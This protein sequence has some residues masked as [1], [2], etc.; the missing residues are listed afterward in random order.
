M[1]SIPYSDYVIFVDESG[2][3]SLES[4]DPE[5][6]VFVLDFC[7]FRKEHYTTAVV[8]R[9]QEFKFRHFGHDLVVLHEHDI[10]RQKP[11]FVFLKSQGKREAFMEELTRL[12]DEAEFTIVAS[13]IDKESHVELYTYP[14][15]PYHVALLFCME[16]A[17]N[18]LREQEQ[19]ENITHI[20]VEKRGKR[21]DRELEL[22]F[23]RIRDG[24]IVSSG[25]KPRSPMPNFEIVFADKR[26][27]STGLQLADLTARPIGR[28]VLDQQS[29]R[30][31]KVIEKKL[32]RGSVSDWYGGHGLKIFPTE[33]PL[34][35]GLVSPS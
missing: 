15:N 7:I 23:R 4:I 20:V 34:H 13:V 25:L 30:P 26:I 1:N 31:W 27:N 5:Y 6:P 9:V 29:T 35:E 16:R 22:E 18:L 11:P 14:D 19:H 12:V 21:E 28:R 10:R 24:G 2:D 8:P 17:R 32:L 3:H 33:S